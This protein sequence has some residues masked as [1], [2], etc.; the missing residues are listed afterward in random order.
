MDEVCALVGRVRGHVPRLVSVRMG[1]CMP[2]PLALS[3]CPTCPAPHTPHTPPHTPHPTPTPTTPMPSLP[4]PQMANNLALSFLSEVSTHLA[5]QY[6]GC[7]TAVQPV[8]NN[9]YEAKYTQEYDAFQVRRA[10]SYSCD[11]CCLPC[12]CPRAFARAMLL[13]QSPAGNG[14]R[15]GIGG[16][17]TCETWGV[18]GRG[19]R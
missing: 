10:Q 4:S 9:E 6:P 16:E 12:M 11:G 13:P 2:P 14:V 18:R 15:L 1:G 8:Y 19:R 5:R 7:F 3:F 17:V